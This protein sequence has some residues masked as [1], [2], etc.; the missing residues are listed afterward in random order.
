MV[1]PLRKGKPS[2]FIIIITILAHLFSSG[3]YYKSR[4]SQVV[5]R[6]AIST[7]V[8]DYKA[9][10]IERFWT[11]K[12]NLFIT[13]AGKNL[14]REEVQPIKENYEEYKSKNAGTALAFGGLL[15]LGAV[16]GAALSG[17][18][19]ETYEGEGYYQEEETT[20]LYIGLIICGIAGLPIAIAGIHGLA[21]DGKKNFLGTSP[22][23]IEEKET[24]V[25]SQKIPK[26][27]AARL[28]IVGKTELTALFGIKGKIVFNFEK[29]TEDV[30]DA[31]RS[32]VK[33]RGMELLDRNY[34]LV[35]TLRILN[36]PRS[37]R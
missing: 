23:A 18:E 36:Y 12:N 30:K 14:V 28:N 35:G 3:C 11:E 20:T 8:V 15:M 25:E 4:V 1:R 31:I 29:E 33:T 17:T 13:L 34:N 10:E 2:H 22:G 24:V 26:D 37:S 27:I 7:E 16:L 19:T 6:D 21:V 9:V 5:R 32:I